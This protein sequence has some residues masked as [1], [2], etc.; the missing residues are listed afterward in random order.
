VNLSIAEKMRI[1]FQVTPDGAALRALVA[2]SK[3]ALI[4]DA[5]LGTGLT[6]EVKEPHRGLIDAMNSSNTPILAVDLPSGLDC[7]TG[8]PLGVSVRAKRTVTFAALKVGFAH[9]K[10]LTGEV[11]VVPI[12]CPV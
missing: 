10:E 7:D 8:K 2:R 12:G 9:A 3:P 11:T 1:P 4:A 6:T 5:L